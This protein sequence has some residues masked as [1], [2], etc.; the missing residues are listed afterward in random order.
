MNITSKYGFRL[1]VILSVF[2]GF[3]ALVD[4]LFPSL[5]SAELQEYFNSAELTSYGGFLATTSIALPFLGL[6]SLIGI[7]MFRSWGRTL[8]VGLTIV[9]ILFLPFFN[10]QISSGLSAAFSTL[11]TL[12]SGMII[13]LMYVAPVNEYFKNTNITNS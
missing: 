12:T 10:E 4:L 3:G 5:L 6:I 1:F 8:Y 7:L 13:I 9:G 11:S 2:V